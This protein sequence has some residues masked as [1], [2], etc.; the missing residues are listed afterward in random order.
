[1][2]PCGLREARC[3]CSGTSLS[4]LVQP[5]VDVGC[6]G[7][8]S[9]AAAPHQGRALPIP[10]KSHPPPHARPDPGTGPQA[11]AGSQ[12]PPLAGFPPCQLAS[13]TQP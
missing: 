6:G 1:M 13:S 7:L 12:R 3:A 11:L 2:G 9:V 4:S 10:G 5:E 8:A